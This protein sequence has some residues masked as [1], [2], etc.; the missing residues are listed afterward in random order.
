MMWYNRRNPLNRIEIFPIDVNFESYMC[1]HFP[2]LGTGYCIYDV[3]L[4]GAAVPPS[5]IRTAHNIGLQ[6]LR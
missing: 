2:V 6:N 3:E 1:R 5:T 4:C